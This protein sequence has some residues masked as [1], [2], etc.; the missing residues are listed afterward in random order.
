MQQQQVQSQMELVAAQVKRELATALEKE[1]KAQAEGANVGVN[2]FQVLIDALS[3]G[4]KSSANQA[5]S[6]IDAHKADSARMM[7]EKPAAGGSK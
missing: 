7:A 2:V 4:Q 5:K 6:L 3:Q 1:A